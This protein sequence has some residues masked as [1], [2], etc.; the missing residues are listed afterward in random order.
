MI[1]DTE[2]A[3][4]AAVVDLQARLTT[5]PSPNGRLPVV[6]INGN[7][8]PLLEWLSKMTN[9]ASF[10]TRRDYQRYGCSEH[11]SDKHIHTT[12]HSGR[13]SVTGAKATILLF[14]IEPFVWLKRPDVEQL[15]GLGLMSEMRSQS[16]ND[17]K[18]LGWALPLQAQGKKAS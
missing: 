12:S 18:R 11:C 13:W 4:I 15:L 17:M 9:S 5:R 14:N 6:E 16:I 1:A 8:W 10:E 2:L 3:Y 7:N